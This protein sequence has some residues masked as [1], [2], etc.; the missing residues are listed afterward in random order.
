MG[1]VGD[2]MTVR[3][4]EKFDIT[5]CIYSSIPATLYIRNYKQTAWLPASFGNCT[6]AP[7]HPLYVTLVNFRKSSKAYQKAAILIIYLPHN[8]S[9]TTSLLLMVQI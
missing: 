4:I 1:P 6:H 7:S 3:T 8:V 2:I 5:Q 9:Y